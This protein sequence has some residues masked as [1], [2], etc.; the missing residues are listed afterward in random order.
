MK[1]S[2]LYFENKCVSFKVHYKGLTLN[3][4]VKQLGF[5]RVSTFLTNP[6]QGQCEDLVLFVEDDSETLIRLSETCLFSWV[7]YDAW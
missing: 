6:K 3:L 4:I 2:C 1:K 5:F 7:T